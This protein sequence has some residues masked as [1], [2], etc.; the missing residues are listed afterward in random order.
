L[1]PVTPDDEH[2]IGYTI[3]DVGRLLRTVFERRVRAVGLT[4]AQW[5]VIARVHRRPGLSQSEVAD[6]LEIEKASAG[7]LVDRME[8]K[9]W[10]TRRADANDRRIN[11][12]HL[13][14]AAERL[15]ATIWPIAEA[16]VDD[17]LS[18][19]SAEERRRLTRLMT[20]VKGKL[21]A[22]AERDPDQGSI[23]AADDQDDEDSKVQTL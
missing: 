2:Y 3:T 20:R 17:A 7:R 21:L 5:L 12:L 14:P 11:R 4:R 10:L 18:D 15:H 13:T 1:L 9:G 22:L 6:L 16:T 23:Q 8:A 19:L